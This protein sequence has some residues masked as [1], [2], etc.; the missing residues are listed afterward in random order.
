MNR[1]TLTTLAAL[2]TVLGAG[3]GYWLARQDHGQRGAAPAAAAKP[4]EP[5]VLYWYDPMQPAQHFDKPGKSPFMDMELVPKYA[6]ESATAGGAGGV[7]I[8]P[9]VTQNL[10]IRLAAVERGRLD[11]P[12]EAAANVLF[13]DREVAIVQA[14]SA[15]FV[16]RVYARAPGDVVAAGAPLA[17]LLV[18][19]WA[20]AQGEFLALLKSGD[21]ELA[22]AA[23]NRLRLLGMPDALIGRVEQG[24][25]P[26]AVVTI[27]APL[28]GVIQ[29]LEVRA[30]MSIAAG[31]TMAKIVGLNSVWLEAAV[32]ESQ[33]T[34]IGVGK[35]IE[36]RF[37]AFPGETFKGRVI[38][39]LPE[40]S[41]E[42][43]TL[44]VRA[45]IA[46]RD[47]RFRPG[48]FAQ[49]RLAAGASAAVL[50][51]PAEAVIRTG[52]RN[53]VIVADGGR[54]QPVEVVTGG[55]ADGRTAI[56]KGLAEGQKVV[57][58]GQ[59]LIDSEASLK[60]VLARL[61]ATPPA[62]AAA[63]LHEAR[64]KIEA[65]EGGEIMISH[66]PIKSLG[67]EAMT[68]GFKLARPELARSLKVGDTIRFSFRQG[69]EGGVIEKLEKDAR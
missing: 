65:I 34:L 59:F 45:E 69:E 52:K 18:P 24:G 23:R 61:G 64:G 58:S 27:V 19:E 8:D 37:A 55:D 17:D 7:K 50:L 12:V 6:D 31:M 30:G 51:V 68:M 54:F 40:T 42:S 35:T 38:A 60:G 46:N 1:L 33:S 22:A 20:G 47:G 43:R 4:A 49:V 9:G 25:R 14:R 62:A 28:G 2:T 32:P 16:E 57:A 39:V 48:M 11:Q 15:G 44:R 41:A 56:L 63:T 3:G 5:K 66:E 36:A 53:V 13:N 21:A 67:W 29:T 26:Q 10:A